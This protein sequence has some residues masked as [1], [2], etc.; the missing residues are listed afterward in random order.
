LAG[1]GAL[2]F[3]DR[4]SGICKSEASG[5]SSIRCRDSLI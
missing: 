4:P 3:T 1:F 5:D 2:T